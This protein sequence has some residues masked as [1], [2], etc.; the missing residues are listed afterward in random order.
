MNARYVILR[1]LLEAGGGLVTLERG[2]AD[3][4]KPD[5]LVRVDRAAI[6][7]AGKRAIGEFLLKLQV[8]KSLG[9]VAQGRALFAGYSEVTAEMLALREVVMARKE[10]RK[11][12]VQPHMY[13]DAQ[14][15]VGLRQFDETAAGMVESF[16]AR[17][18]AEDPELLA[19]WRAE[20]EAVAD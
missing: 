5:V 16:V 9:D 3:D 10:P 13:A 20:A 15:G 17:F 7:T 4:G 11:L 2:E 19:L 12:L 18:P 1:V 8:H 14:G 6:A